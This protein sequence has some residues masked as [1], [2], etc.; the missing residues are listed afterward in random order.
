MLFL[1]ADAGADPSG[2]ILSLALKVTTPLALSAL[3]VLVLFLLYRQVVGRLDSAGTQ[4]AV[5]YV[6][7][8]VLVAIVLGVG[9]YV[10]TQLVGASDGRPRF[11][12]RVSDTADV[13]TGIP[14]AVVH[15]R[16][17]GIRDVTTDAQGSFSVVLAKSFA[18]Q[19]AQVWADAVTYKPSPIQQ[20]IMSADPGPQNIS[21]ERLH[22]ALGTN[23]NVSCIVGKWLEKPNGAYIWSFTANKAG[24][25]ARRTDGWSEGQF[26][27]VDLDWVGSLHWGNGT[28]WMGVTLSPN[29]DCSQLST[30]RD[31]WYQRVP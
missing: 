17:N 12:G 1:I 5:T 28:T 22:G 30:N 26:Q 24:L 21:L 19:T 8:L 6:F 29:K 2:G 16:L 3:L 31:W 14:N 18:N 20:V 25:H 4:K 13:H 9:A 15:I 11:Y 7:I 27:R 23:T 10:T